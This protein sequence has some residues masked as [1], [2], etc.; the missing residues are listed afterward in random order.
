MDA[1][2]GGGADADVEMETDGAL[3]GMAVE[4]HGESALT[5][6]AGGGRHTHG[7]G[8]AAAGWGRR[9]RAASGYAD[10]GA[11]ADQR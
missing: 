7:A 3:S 10:A 2:G 8:A 9:G 11:P 5:G 6:A 4:Q 1:G